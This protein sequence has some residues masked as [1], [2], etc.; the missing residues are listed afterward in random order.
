MPCCPSRLRLC[1]ATALGLLLAATAQAQGD[2]TGVYRC[3][4]SYS[5]LPCPGGKGLTV[6]DTRTADQHR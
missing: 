2:G 3:G 6:D 4:N 5:A 1:L